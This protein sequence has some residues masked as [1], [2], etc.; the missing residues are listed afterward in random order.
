ML[1]SLQ[2][3]VTPAVMQRLTLLL[4]HVLSSESVA[5]QR[6]KPHAGR[7]VQLQVV[8]WPPMLPAWPPMVFAVTPA[9]LLEWQAP[10]DEATRGPVDA[11]PA[12]DLTLTLRASNPAQMVLQ[13]LSGQK[14]HIDVSGNAAFAADMSWLM[15][16]LR[17]DVKDDLARWVG[18]MPAQQLGRLGQGIAQAV[19]DMAQRWA[20]KDQP[21]PPTGGGTSTSPPPHQPPSSAP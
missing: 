15:D 19:R 2:S 12:V 11:G 1:E 14:P 10:E 18:Q 9:G 17:W 4:N 21:A 16:N 5:T 8:D 6:L 13:A 3:L 20:A 7:R